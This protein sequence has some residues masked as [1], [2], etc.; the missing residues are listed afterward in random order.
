M[1]KLV[2]VKKPTE[3][4]LIQNTFNAL[5]TEQRQLATKLSEIELDLNEHS[6]VI[7]TLNKLDD[8][9]KCFRLIGGVLVERKICD[10][11]PT[12][13]KNRGEM[14]KIVKTL[15]EQL[16]KKGIEIN[17]FKNKHNIQV[18]GGVTPMSEEV[19]SQG[20]E[21]KADHGGSVI[22]NNV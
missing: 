4:E 2:K 7:D 13:I 14:G 22:V 1:E 3:E 9:R 10:V 15:N 6:I 12:L 11:L 18:R 19:E 5:R 21:K 17:D 16:T 8:E 20:V